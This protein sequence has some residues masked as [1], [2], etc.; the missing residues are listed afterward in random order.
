MPALT[1]H[2]L[3][4]TQLG[5][6]ITGVLDLPEK[7]WP[8]PGQYLAC[9]RLGDLEC[10]AIPLFR[11]FGDLG[12]PCL[13]SIPETWHPG[14]RLAFFPPMGCGFEL[15]KSARRVGLIPFEVS[16]ARILS[17]VEPSLDQGAEIVLFCDPGLP[18]DVLSR[19]PSRVEVL[20]LSSLAEDST[21]PDYVAVDLERSNL[22]S[23]TERV[24]LFNLPGSV[25]VLLR[26][27]MPCLG[28]GA[29]GVCA[30]HTRRGFRFAC[31]DGPVFPLKGLRHVA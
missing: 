5:S 13:A 14:D 10:I 21:W 29:C 26:T 3:E 4:L 22:V 7:Y 25:E 16:P 24:D 31:T 8:K 30:V 6:E 9:Q 15:P 18:A 2:L 11:A 19:L 23:L 20:P 12:Q 27:P 1:T 17:L 28:I